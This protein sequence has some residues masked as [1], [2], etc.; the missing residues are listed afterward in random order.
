[1]KKLQ[2][3]SG[4]MLA[5]LTSFISFS[6]S[7]KVQELTPLQEEISIKAS[8]YDFFYFTD[9]YFKKTHN[10]ASVPALPPRPWTEAVRISSISSC[11][12]SEEGEN[13]KA[14]GIV[15]RIGILSFQDD[16]IELHL[17]NEL[18]S[19]RTAGNL[20]FYQATPVYSLYRSTFFNDMERKLSGPHPFLVQFDPIQKISFPIINVENLLPGE[21]E[22]DAE[23]TEIIDYIWDGKVFSCAAKQ[24][25]VIEERVGSRE[26]ISFSYKN[27]Q[28]KEDLL[29]ITPETAS[30]EIF[31]TPSSMGAFKENQKF[32]NFENAPEK[33]QDLLSPL[34]NADFLIT[35]RNAGGHSPRRYKHEVSA[36]DEN[37]FAFADALLAPSW[38]AA[39]FQDGTIFMKGALES[40]PIFNKGRPVVLRL[41]KLPNSFQ[42][43]GFAITGKY[44]YASW[45][46][47][48]FY[49]VKRSGFLCVD[50]GKILY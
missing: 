26:E 32:Q 40:S 36:S 47:T 17:D 24:K 23:N 35:V 49:M 38:C 10:V 20:V 33:L 8:S 27:F 22:S 43:S 37:R 19:S 12:I 28:V 5:L 18:F 13:A 48:D 39:L 1:M 11:D 2:L 15:N 41:P 3:M 4:A 45:E 46:E 16:R 21:S 34:K 42:Y 9:R 25:K 50:L 30:K 7:K 6:C 29:S 44:L 14:Y 31:I